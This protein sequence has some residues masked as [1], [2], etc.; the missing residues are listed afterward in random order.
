MIRNFPKYFEKLRNYKFATHR[1]KSNTH[2]C[3]ML[4]VMHVQ[5]NNKLLI[6]VKFTLSLDFEQTERLGNGLF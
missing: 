1:Q 2:Y 6:K 3:I 4:Q 5:N